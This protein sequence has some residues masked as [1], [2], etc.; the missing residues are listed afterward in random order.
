MNEVKF[1]ANK[2]EVEA[3]DERVTALEEGGGG[4][5][6]A[7]ALF[8]NI[9]QVEG[10]TYRLSKTAS[11]IMDAFNAGKYISIQYP[12]SHTEQ[13]LTYNDIE[14][15]QLTVYSTASEGRAFVFQNL[16]TNRRGFFTFSN[17][18][19]YPEGNIL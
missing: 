6:G 9:T 15:L 11:E 2:K 13:G 17:D 14:V 3:L 8:L 5:G 19:D 10:G 12:R 7:G 1:K 18:G 4:G 16:G